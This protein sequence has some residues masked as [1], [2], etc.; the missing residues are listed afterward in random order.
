MRI[1]FLSAALATCVGCV[2]YESSA[3]H[4]P[5]NAHDRNGDGYVSHN[6]WIAAGGMEGAIRPS[7]KKEFTPPTP[8]EK[9]A[10]KLMTRFADLGEETP[11]TPL[12]FH[13]PPGARIARVEF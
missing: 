4:R 6:E 3:V 2:S 12:V 7:D 11:M 10:E 9:A 8:A 13:S 5:V 1:F